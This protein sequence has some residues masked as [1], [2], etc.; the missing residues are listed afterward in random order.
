M[1]GKPE[2]NSYSVFKFLLK[3]FS[4]FGPL[5]NSQGFNLI[6]LMIVVT[7]VG[8]MAAVSIPLYKGYIQRARVKQ[9]VYPGLHIIETNIGLFYAMNGSLP[10]PSRLPSMWAE[11]DT[12]Y[13]KVP[14]NETQ[15]E[16]S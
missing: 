11:A 4:T 13:F 8:I 15:L 1:K 16:N 9:L 5:R 6:E 3:K 10:D 14:L 2:G 7:I 12:T